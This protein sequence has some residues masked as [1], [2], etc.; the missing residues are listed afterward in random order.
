VS[1]RIAFAS[2][3]EYIDQH[4]GSARYFQVYDLADNG[5]HAHIETRKMEALCTDSCDGGFDHLLKA[6]ND[7][8]AVFI[9]K[10]GQTAA[11]FMISQG[12]RV[13]EAS[14]RVEDIMAKL[15]EENFL[16]EEKEKTLEQNIHG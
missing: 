1:Y 4:F 12:K 16:E 6:L 5:N 14:G 11:A 3:G 2:N 10:I 13:F 7:C 15:A 9:N 8:D